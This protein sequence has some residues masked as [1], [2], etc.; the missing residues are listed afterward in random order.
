MISPDVQERALRRS[1][2]RRWKNL[3]ETKALRMHVPDQYEFLLKFPNHFKK[4]RDAFHVYL[5]TEKMT[6]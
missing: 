1:L 6:R 4:V 2:Y 3:P 5:I